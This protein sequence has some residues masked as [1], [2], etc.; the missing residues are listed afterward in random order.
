MPARHPRRLATPLVLLSG[1]LAACA[2]H[3]LGDDWEQL[4]REARTARALEVLE[5]ILA[6]G[7]DGAGRP[8][9]DRE[10]LA[11][12]GREARYLSRDDPRAQPSRLRWGAIEAVESQPLTNLP[13]RP[14]TLYVYLREEGAGEVLDRIT[15]A[16]AHAGLA[17]PYLLLPSRPRWS[18]SRMVL[19]LQHLERAGVAALTSARGAE[20]V[21]LPR[22]DE[23][24][25]APEPPPSEPEASSPAPAPAPA[26]GP[27]PAPSEP[28]SSPGPS[29]G[30]T[31]PTGRLGVEEIEQRL[32]K[33]KEWRERGLIEEDEYQSSRRA[34]LERL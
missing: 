11:I 30:P 19:A 8:F 20:E 17:S 18:R 16:L 13:S 23:V 2:A 6:G 15:P 4:G 12:D 29:A 21:L 28:R 34:L 26:P 27:A 9:D 32:L 1:L 3:P 25:R 31:P 22:E 33:L 10:V 24:E 5:Q 14:E 7:V